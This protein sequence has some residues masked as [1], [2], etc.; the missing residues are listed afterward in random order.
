MLHWNATIERIQLEVGWADKVLNGTIR[1]RQLTWRD[2]DAFCDLWANSPEEI[3]EFDVTAERGPDGFASFELQERPVLNALFDGTTMV[4]CVSFSNRTTIV[5]GKRLSVRFG[6]AMRVHKDHR[7]H[8]YAN[9]VRSLPWGIGLNMWTE[10]QYDYIRGRNMTMERWNRKNMPE[11][12][13]VPKR[14]DDVP[15]IP[16]TVLQYPAKVASGSDEHIRN[17]RPDDLD[18]CAAMI[19]RAHAG[20]DLFRPYTPE[21]LA[22]RLDPGFVP[23]G[24]AVTARPYT[25]DDFYVVERGGAIVAC[26]GAW[27][28]GRDIRERWRHRESGAERILSVMTMLDICYAPGHEDALAALIERFT[29]LAH[30]N[31]R[32]YV[33]AP[34]ETMPGVAAL[35]TSRE[36]VPETRY[37]QWRTETPALKSPAHLDLVY[38]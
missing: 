20:L 36:P 30:D 26:A 22:D 8:G 24:P 37:L 35:L 10:V 32:D 27:D 29:G 13:S 34:L 28:R 2:N 7:R 14:D 6:Q 3:G 15:G 17:A 4:A 16:T 18:A 11:V 31:G 33:V 38:W 12:G 25:Y 9:W 21:F 1:W 5:G 19:N 23:E